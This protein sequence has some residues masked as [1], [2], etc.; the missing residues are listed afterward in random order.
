MDARRSSPLAHSRSIAIGN[1][2]ADAGHDLATHLRAVSE[3]A[4]QF[5]TP[6][7]SQAWAQ[8]AGLWHDLGKY[9]P[10]FQRMLEAADAG[11]A[12]IEGGPQRVTHSNAG[13]LHAQERYP[14]GS[15]RVLAALIAG[16]HAG[17]PD[18]HSDDGR[19]ASLSVRLASDTARSEYAEALEQ[20]PP[21]DILNPDVTP[22]TACPGGSEGFA[23]WQRMLFSCLVDADFLDTERYCDPKRAADRGRTP[24]LHTM[25][26]AYDVHMAALAARVT[27]SGSHSP[28]NDARA[29]VLRQCR[30][31]GRRTD[32]GPGFFRLTVPTGGGKTLASLGFALEH[33]V[34]HA[35]RRIVYAIPYTSIIEQT[36]QVFRDVFAS[37]GEDTVVEHHSNLDVDPSRENHRTR[38]AAE[39][40][41]APLIVTTNVQ[42]FE[43]LHAARTSRC[44]KLH[45]LVNAVIVLDE[46]QMLPRDFLGP[47][48]QSLRLL[49]DCY[50]ATVVLC[51]ATQPALGSRVAPVTGK[52]TLRGIDRATDLI[53][54][55]EHLFD[56]LRRV[57]IRVPADLRAP[58]PWEVVAT[59][60]RDTPCAL[61]IVN[62]RRQARDLHRQ[63]NDPFAVHLSALMCASHRSA[64][65]SG[66]RER[67]AARRGG[68]DDR[69][70]RVVSTS[71]VEA[72]VDLDFPVV[73]RALAGLD[74]IA[75]AAGRC[76][77]EGR[78]ERPGMVHVFIPP[79]APPPGQARQG[80]QTTQELITTGLVA[81]L[82]APETFRRY[83]DHFYGKD[84][85]GRFDTQDILG[86]Q[87]PERAALR[88]ASD[89]FRVID[90]ASETVIV[91]YV[92]PDEAASPV[93]G[94]LAALAKDGKLTWARRKL[95]RF[96]VSVPRRTLDLMIA[97]R[98]VVEVA[99]LWLAQDTRYDPTF[100][101]LL[102]DDHGAGEGFHC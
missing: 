17:L 61:A 91:P 54:D 45:N 32:L 92:P 27:I 89:R 53:D 35:R 8:L 55:P 85:N 81:D 66:I 21:S 14:K 43:S 37:L 80:A 73:F 82:L 31:K 39:N 16:H 46:A 48:L 76:N 29:N 7:G 101:L 60:I 83:F 62:M 38:L 25:L 49:V 18:L 26:A 58:T 2:P 36:A 69:P 100:G 72:G 98:D 3:L 13:A 74:A 24:P 93:H 50:G 47:I 10:A 77:R 15:G 59:Q 99:G 63:L 56:T 40:W 67:L 57:E 30:E 97:Q 95:Q 88:T 6:F 22:L 34:A 75:Q 42:L 4:S 19:K 94:W 87:T 96:T 64:C 70:L 90:D 52:V 78:L 79:Q 71:L 28:V 23:L 44:R 12:H 68:T 84:A 102:P 11:E 1:G 51:T 41:D 9:R 20:G 33:A 5:A 86:L 65:I